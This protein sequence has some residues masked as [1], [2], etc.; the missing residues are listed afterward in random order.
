MRPSMPVK[1]NSDA[2]VYLGKIWKKLDH[3]LKQAYIDLA[4]EER[5]LHKLLFPSYKY[6]PKK[7]QPLKGIKKNKKTKPMPLDTSTNDITFCHMPDDIFFACTDLDLSTAPETTTETDIVEPLFKYIPPILHPRSEC[8]DSTAN[9][10]ANNIMLDNIGETKIEDN[11]FESSINYV[12]PVF[13]PCFD[14]MDAYDC[15]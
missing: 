2:S 15:Q 11:I 10:T 7:N 5:K 14:I 8:T 9:T 13:Y 3:S 6:Q 12:P 4:N 1:S